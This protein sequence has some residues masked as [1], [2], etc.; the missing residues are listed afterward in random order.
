MTT[1]RPYK[2]RR[3]LE[4]VV[5]D[6]RRNSGKQFEPK[7]V[8]CFCRAL[9]KEVNGATRNARIIRMLGR[10]YVERDKVAPLLQALIEDLESG[11]LSTT[12]GNA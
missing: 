5:D 12:A 3:D 11:A 7:V 4:A 10:D 2:R 1:D 8:A 9:L 6:L